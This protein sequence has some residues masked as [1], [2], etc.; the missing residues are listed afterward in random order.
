MKESAYNR[1]EHE[2]MAR[3]YGVWFMRS[4]LATLVPKVVV[5][6]ILLVQLRNYA[7]IKHVLANSP[8]FLNVRE[9]FGFFV[10][11]LSGTEVQAI[12][13]VAGILVLTL[14]LLRD[15]M[16]RLEADARASAIALFVR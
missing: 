2:T 6:V 7:S 5:A 13:L 14:W 4:I 10:S 8:S 12:V 11:A 9:S 15:A 1:V 3:V 16:R